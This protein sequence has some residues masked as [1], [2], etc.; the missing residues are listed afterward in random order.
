M[1]QHKRAL[2]ISCFD[3][4]YY[5]RIEPIAE[6][7]EEKGYRV[8]ILVS[9]YQHV[10]KEYIY[11]RNDRCTY[12]HV[13][14]YKK[15][16]SVK[17]IASHM[18]FGVK[19]NQFLG[20]C[21]PDLIYLILPPNNT[22]VY[23]NQYKRK[24][25]CCKYIVDIID[26]W[27][28]SMPLRGLKRTLPAL[29]WKRMRDESLKT[30][31]CI[32]TECKLYQKKLN[33]LSDLDKTGTLYLYKRQSREEYQLVRQIIADRENRGITV[34]EDHF[35]FAYL[36]SIN[37]IIDIDG[38]CNFLNSL[39]GKGIRITVEIIGDGERRE[40]F[41]ARLKSAGVICNYHGMIYD[42]TEKIK[43][44]TPCD[45]AFNMMKKTS[46]VG[47]TIK[48]I[49][50]FSYGLP[51]VNN[52]RG[53]TWNLVHKYGIGV[54]IDG[55]H[56]QSISAVDRTKILSIFQK[57]FSREAF[58]EKCRKILSCVDESADTCTKQI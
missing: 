27:P 39:T 33:N 12:I 2:I 36:G 28:E 37:N 49:D 47:L 24:N 43:I 15:N 11:D 21:Q 58:A 46:Q 57:Y 20:T 41:L 23:C 7:L 54:N 26:L 50:Y 25:P 55:S 17:R 8:K 38:I 9:D 13:P 31:D 34:T 19:V 48:S 32:F 29:L 40:E 14:G 16:L 5:N 56:I 51:L 1:K 6:I 42:E 35:S 53:D 22:A 10:K 4:W 44:L 30:A 45:Y 18:L 52:I 3:T